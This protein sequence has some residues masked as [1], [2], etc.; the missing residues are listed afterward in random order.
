MYLLVGYKENPYYLVELFD[1]RNLMKYKSSNE[2]YDFIIII[3]N[4]TGLFIKN[5]MPE[6][7][8]HKFEKSIL[9]R[10]LYLI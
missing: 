1:D 3:K 2:Q 10:I 6:G 4:E 9:P 7:S 5:L 8:I